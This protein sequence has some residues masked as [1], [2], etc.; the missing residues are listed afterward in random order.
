MI[1]DLHNDMAISKNSEFIKDFVGDNTVALA[2]FSTHLEEE[3]AFCFAKMAS[4]I[5]KVAFEDISFTD[6]ITRIFE[7]NPLYLSLTW[8]YDNRFAGGAME[9]GELTLKGIETIKKINDNGF[10]LD[11]AHLNRKSFFKAVSIADRVICSHTCFDGVNQ[12]RRNLTD[13]QIKTIIEKDGIIGLTF[14]DDFLTAKN[15]ANINDIYR[16][17]DY[18]A[19]KFGVENLAIGSDFFGTDFLDDINT[20]S[21]FNKLQELLINHGYNNN[22]V[23]RIFFLNAKN[24]FDRHLR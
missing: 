24:Y 12:H 19:Q 13:E 18:F 16:H 4:K 3:N 7:F 2:I 1:F 8:N 11:T 14:V 17:I 21:H 22:D 6:N 9:E 20:Y 5:S 10:I 23:E 15:Y